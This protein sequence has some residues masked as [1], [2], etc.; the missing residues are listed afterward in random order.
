MFW[1]LPVSSPLVYPC[2]GCTLLSL[3][4]PWVF[5]HR[6]R[7]KEDSKYLLKKW[8]PPRFCTYFILCLECSA[9]FLSSE[10]CLSCLTQLSWSSLR[11]PPTRCAVRGGGSHALPE[12]PS[13]PQLQPSWHCSGLLR[14]PFL[15]RRRATLSAATGLRMWALGLRSLRLESYLYQFWLYHLDKAISVLCSLL[16]DE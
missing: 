9:P 14:L 12:T 8:M 15:P 4:H 16:P 13:F 6:A 5:Q 10:M 1:K 11:E 2:T 3:I 7:S